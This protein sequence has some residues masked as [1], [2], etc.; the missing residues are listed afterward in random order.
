MLPRM[1]C[2][3]DG[4]V[5]RYLAAINTTNLKGRATSQTAANT[6]AEGEET[7]YRY[8]HNVLL[9]WGL[10]QSQHHQK[11]ASNANV[12]QVRANQHHNHDNAKKDR[13]ETKQGNT[14]R[15]KHLA[16]PFP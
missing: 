2:I 3:L 9:K 6:T 8:I 7:Q 11:N 16:S 14:E 12:P 10:S 15:V 4:I 1:D 5:L 13:E